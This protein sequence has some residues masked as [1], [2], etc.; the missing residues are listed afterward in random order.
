MSSALVR[1]G[2]RYPWPGPALRL[3]NYLALYIFIS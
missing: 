2:K 1:M 3:Q